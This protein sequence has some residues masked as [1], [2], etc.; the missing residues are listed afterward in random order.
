MEKL[1]TWT[2]RL[3]AEDESL[4][5]RVKQ[6]RNLFGSFSRL[7]EPIPTLP[8]ITATAGQP[9]SSTT[10][11]PPDIVKPNFSL[12][13]PKMKKNEDMLA[14]GE[15]LILPL[16]PK[17]PGSAR[18]KGKVRSGQMLGEKSI[19]EFEE[20]VQSMSGLLHACGLKC[21]P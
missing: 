19:A 2:A 11:L 6:Y 9:H 16:P 1:R 17:V 3:Y 21:R 10:S 15:Q 7:V 12:P 18:K 8:P 4:N 13:V 5:T 20:L 14:F